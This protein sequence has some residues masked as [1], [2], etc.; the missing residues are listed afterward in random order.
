MGDVINAGIIH[1][2]TGDLFD[3]NVEG[4]KRVNLHLICRDYNAI[5]EGS[6]PYVV[7]RFDSIGVPWPKEVAPDVV[8][9]V[10]RP[11]LTKYRLHKCQL[12]AD[13]L[14]ADIEKIGRIRKEVE[15][16]SEEA[17]DTLKSLL[18]DEENETEGYL[19]NKLIEIRDLSKQL[20]VKSNG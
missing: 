20:G 14:R 8:T 12:R 7:F 5:E 4:K 15:T 19:R 18:E 2:E 9:Q 1:A 17:Q 16:L 11:L 13:E 6:K 3:V 10:L